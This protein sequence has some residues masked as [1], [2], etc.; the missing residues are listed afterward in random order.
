MKYRLEYS[1]ASLVLFAD[2]EVSTRILEKT[3]RFHSSR[4]AWAVSSIDHEESSEFLYAHALFTDLKE[5]PTRDL[6][7]VALL[8]VKTAPTRSFIGPE[9]A[10]DPVY[11]GRGVV[12]LLNDRKYRL[13]GNVFFSLKAR[14]SSGKL[15]NSPHTYTVTGAP[16]FHPPAI[17][18]YPV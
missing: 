14:A 17:E 16:I 12:A 3:S 4:V 13:A 8:Q 10:V 7:S 11:V 15:S 5:M 2:S 1:N 18:V 9:R 6:I